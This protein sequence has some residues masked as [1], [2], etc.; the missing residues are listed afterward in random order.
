PLNPADTALDSLI[1]VVSAT[2]TAGVA[3][4]ATRRVDIVAGPK[5]SVVSP[6]NGD[7]IPAGV[8]LSVG[9]RAQHPNGV[10]R[11]DIRVQGEKNWPTKLDT[12]FSQVYD[13]S[14]RD[15]TFNGVARIPIDAPLR[16]RVT[17]TATAV[18]VDRQP[19]SASPIAVFVRSASSA[20]PRVTQ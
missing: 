9:A 12:T 3:D 19:G 6:T 8:G 5:V 1:V 7:S 16:G 17:V 10:G 4:T 18:D 20:Q 2:D 13:D 11:I 15:I 14:P